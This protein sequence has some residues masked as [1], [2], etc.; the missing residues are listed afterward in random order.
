MTNANISIDEQA[1]QSAIQT[2]TS[3]TCRLSSDGLYLD[4]SNSKASASLSMFG[5]HLCS[6]IANKDGRERLWI[7]DSAMFDASTPIRGG[8]PICWPWFGANN[9]IN[10]APSHGFVRNQMWRLNQAKEVKDEN[11]EVVETHCYLKPTSLG[12]FST[13]ATLNLTLMLKVSTYCEITL[14]TENQSSQ[15]VEVSQAIHSY[16]AIEDINQV[17]INGLH[18]TYYNKLD[19]THNNVS[20]SLYTIKQE[21]DRVHQRAVKS[22]TDERISLSDGDKNIINIL[23]SGHNST[24]VWNPWIEKSAKMKDMSE[25]GYKTML[26]IEAATEPRE[27]LL[28]GQKLVLT[29]KFD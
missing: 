26:C 27:A 18:G 19:N 9:K 16:F 6:F 10:D 8:V 17:V 3:L 28:P 23:H 29:Q 2:F 1:L 12:M 21:T 15:R 11:G 22:V 7:S 20:P 5:A 25:G 4:I 24:V 13:P 14:I